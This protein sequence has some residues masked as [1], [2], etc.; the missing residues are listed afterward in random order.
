MVVLCL[1]IMEKYI[2]HVDKIG[3]VGLSTKTKKV[4][5]FVPDL[6][7][8]GAEKVCVNLANYLVC[9]GLEVDLV[10]MNDNG[11]LKNSL[12]DKVKYVCLLK[13]PVNNA[14]LL[15]FLSVITMSRYLKVN[16]PGVL[17][18]TVFGA[19]LVAI[20]GSKLAN[21][22]TP[23][24]IREA[25]SLHNYG[26]VKR[27]LMK[28][29][30]PLASRIIAVSVKGAK[31]LEE[32]LPGVESKIQVIR[33]GVNVK[34]VLS[35]SKQPINTKKSYGSYIVAVGRLV[36]A[37]G[38]DVLIS[39]FEKVSRSRD[40]INLVI[41]GEGEERDGLEALILKLGLENR[42]FL[43]GFEL[44]PYP[45]IRQAELFVL[46]SRWEGFP[47]VL[48]EAVCLGVNVI[49]TNCKYGPEEI[50]KNGRKERLVPIN[51]AGA[52]SKAMNDALMTNDRYVLDDCYNN[53][54]IFEKY[55]E[56]IK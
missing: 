21:I 29:T 4:T 53:D 38:F 43:P 15:F 6:N 35:L 27:L 12:D 17:I 26:V 41:F 48:I 2:S 52:L 19:N 49:S 47:N 20:I 50:L 5:L 46:S 42:V 3:V 37:K 28:I 1:S 54:Y 45:Y 8:G 14:I 24:V 34:E 9:K 39:A 16:S 23:I 11:P 36:E 10:V 25:S 30:Y 18:S 44:N 13:K 55:L 33:N 31:E 56:F 7:I 51:D 32:R 40:N 22:S